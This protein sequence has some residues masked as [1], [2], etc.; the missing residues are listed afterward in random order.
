M[1]VGWPKEPSS[2]SGGF[3]DFRA[4]T[5]MYLV[6]YSLIHLIVATITA[7]YARS[8]EAAFREMVLRADALAEADA[9]LVVR[10][11]AL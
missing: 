5:R 4:D 11:Q 7:L 10:N 6:F 1:A 8:L 9:V 3:P 2:L